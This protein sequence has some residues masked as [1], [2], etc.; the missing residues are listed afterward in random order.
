MTRV[1]HLITSFNRGGIETWLIS[2][3]REIPRG[4]YQMDVCCKGTDIGPLASLAEQAGAK[5]ISCPLGPA[6]VGF[7]AKLQRIL[8]EGK[9]DI[10]H[11]HLEAYSG[12]PVWVAHQVKV[13]VITSFHNNH[14]EAQTSLTRLPIIRQ[15]RSVYS[16]ISIA[17]ALRN[18]RLVTGCS[19]GVINSLDPD[20]KKLQTRS[21][22]LYY[23][24]NIPD[25]AT[26]EECAQLRKE[27][28][29]EPDTPIILHVG[30]LIEQKN[31][32]GL[33]SV[34]QQILQQVPTAKLLLVGKGPLEQMIE[35]SINQRGLSHAVRLLGARDDVPSLMSKCDIF[36]FPSIHEGLGVV[37][38]EANA[39]GLPVIGSRV[40]GLMEAVRDGETGILKE[41]EDIEGMAAS[42]I[43]L[44][45]DFS[46]AQ[47]MKN[48]AR[49]WIEDNFSTEVSAKRLLDIYDSLA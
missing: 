23:G 16:V 33:L 44:I 5:V 28:G 29:W 4:K 38:L 19:Q 27:F 9:Y 46:Y 13:P 45:K 24:V 17:Y 35:K 47:Q 15:I 14:F 32:L 3:L 12:F 31:H 48:S 1:L 11:N 25:L 37:V 18:S 20:G 41:V 8:K 49:T 6:H 42:A 30:R 22:V 2:M 43:A 39:S 10:L 36:L 26:P 21:R 7:A 40:P 34:F